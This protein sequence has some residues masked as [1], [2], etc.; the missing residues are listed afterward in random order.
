VDRLPS[1]REGGPDHSKKEGPT[2]A[3]KDPDEMLVVL[4]KQLALPNEA[5][6]LREGRPIFD[7]KEVCEVRSPGSKDVRVF[8]ANE[9][10]RWVDD[11]LTGG[12]VKQSYAER[13]SHQYRQFKSHNAQTKTGTPLNFAAFLSEGRRAELR[14]QNVYT[15]E[16]LAAI[17]GAELKNLG[18]GGREMKNSAMA[19][20]EEGKASAPN[21]Q[22]LA[23][24]E[25]LKA[26][27]AILE[28]HAGAQSERRR[29]RVRRDVARR[30][31]G[32]H[33]RANRAGAARVEEH[34]PQDAGA[35]GR[36]LATGQGCM[37]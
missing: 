9:F 5:A 18:P 37:T 10:S 21:K 19:Y 32:L 26:R 3:V 36:E 7:D 6:S 27:N 24:L 20:I 34:E 1:F 25:A 30:A 23:E 14:A 29:Q 28:G 31:A 17:D 8:H 33:R 11:P 2:M 12:Q 15:I 4:F 16:Q 35:D 13:F 22:M